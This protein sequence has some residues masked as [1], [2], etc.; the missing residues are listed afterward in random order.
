[1]G[2][3]LFRLPRRRKRKTNARTGGFS[4]WRI[5]NWAVWLALVLVVTDIIYLSLIW[6]DW[7]TLG[8][9]EIPRAVFISRYA[10]KRNADPSLPPLRWQPVPFQEIPRHL[11]HAAVAAEDA[12][13]FEHNGVDLVAIRD[14]L[15]DNLDDMQFKRGGSTISQQTVKNLFLSSSRDPLRKWHELVLTLGMEVSISKRRVLEIYLNVA[16]FDEGVYG[17]AAAAQHFWGQPVWSLMPWQSAEL[18]ACLPSPRK[19]NPHTRSRRFLN[20]AE[21][22]RGWMLVQDYNHPNG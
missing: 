12:R 9:G 2:F 21:R 3:S 15:R 17:A 4:V 10:Q 1:M 6:P 18:A 8:S 7:S 20:R 5:F 22:I 14:A 13:F 11:R 16:E 19:D